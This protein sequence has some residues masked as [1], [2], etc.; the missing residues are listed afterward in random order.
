MET[1]KII[2]LGVPCYKAHP[3]I[4][5]LLASLQTQTT[6]GI[7]TVI[8]AND[9]PEDNG[10]YEQ[11]KAMYP[12]IDIVTVD[13]ENNAGPGIARQRALDKAVELRLPWI[14]FMDADDVFFGPYS[15]ENLVNNVTPNCIEV[16]GTFFQE[17]DQGNINAAQR[18]QLMQSGGQIPPRLMPRNEVGH[19]WVFGRL[20]NVHFLH[21]NKIGFS[22]LRAMEDGELNWKI[23]MTIE[24]SPWMIN[25]IDEPIYIWKT[26]SEHSITRIGVEE[27]GGE[28]VYNRSLCQVGATVAAINAIKFCKARNPFNGGITRFTTEMMVGQYFT[29]I[30]CVDKKPFLAEQNFWNAKRFYHAVYKEIENQIS[31]EILKN[32]YTMHYAGSAQDM[33]G[34]IPSMTFF[35]FMDKVKTEPYGG[36]DEWNEIRSKLPDWLIELEKKSGVLG[37]EDFIPYDGEE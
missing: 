19:P 36:R 11:Y 2:A 18:M 21:E 8:L 22:T 7:C 34:F 10:S 26:G 20:Y 35:E 32:I 16:M 4:K 9:W 31:D 25:K 13:C 28:P 17:I 5:N 6:R 29:Y 33:L 23:R 15:L 37:E 3:T 30:Q 1:K 14:T 27:N 12:D 24:G